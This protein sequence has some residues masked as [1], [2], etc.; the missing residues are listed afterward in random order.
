MTNSK[1]MAIFIFKL[2][3]QTIKFGVC[4]ASAPAFGTYS[5]IL[6][7]LGEFKRAAEIAHVADSLSKRPECRATR[8]RVMMQVHGYTM[9]WTSPA[10]TCMKH[11]LRSLEIGLKKGDLENAFFSA[12]MYILIAN[13][14]AGRPLGLVKSDIEDLGQQMLVYNQTAIYNM[15]RPHLQFVLNMIG[16]NP[17]SSSSAFLSGEVME[18]D[19]LM[20]HLASTKHKYLQDQARVLQLTLA[21]YFDDL[22]LAWRMVKESRN[23]YRTNLSQVTIWR[24]EFFAGLTAYAL[25]RNSNGGTYSRTRLRPS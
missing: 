16:E 21:V 11:L 5:V 10:K 9:A 4:E 1:Y 24:R 17:D 8:S 19:S 18:F 14:V 15:A 22:S 13:C 20:E 6:I 7:S 12:Y 3:R 23:C 2:V 25:A